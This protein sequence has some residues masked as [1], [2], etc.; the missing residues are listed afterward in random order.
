[1]SIKWDGSTW[2]D[3]IGDVPRCSIA[4][5]DDDVARLML[6][7]LEITYPCLEFD[8]LAGIASLFADAIRPL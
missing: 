7:R 6:R 4:G 3:G 2:A 8:D 5:S 1:M